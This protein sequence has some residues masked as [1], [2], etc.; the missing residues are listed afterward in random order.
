MKHYCITGGIAAGKS[1]V[2][3]LLR[4]HGIEVYDCDAG[5]KRLM[6]HDPELRRQLLDLIGPMAYNAGGLNR[7]AVAQF[8]LASEAN[9]QAVGAIVHPR[10]IEDFYASGLTWMESAIVYEAHLEQY[11]DSVVA[12]V[13]PDDLRRQRLMARD[14]ITEQQAQ[15][16]LDA[17]TPQQTIADRAGYVIINDGRPLEPQIR[18]LIG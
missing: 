2:C 14:N 1:H 9:K 10:V 16:W 7:R 15:Q 6:N 5:A 8:L 17:Q 3:R 18:Q 4:Q 13:A 11:V 12:V